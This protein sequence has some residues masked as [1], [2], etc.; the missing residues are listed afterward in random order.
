MCGIAGICSWEG[1]LNPDLA[2]SMTAQLVHR[3]PDAEGLHT[4]DR[5]ALGV[6]RLAIMDPEHGHQPLYN[7]TREVV[8]V[9][10]GEIYNHEQLRTQLEA[11]GHRLSSRSDGAVLAHLYEELGSG[12]VKALNGIFAIA[13]WD[14]RAEILVLARDPFGVKPLYWTQA[15]TRVLFASELKAL[16]VDP[17]LS[18]SLDYD[19]IND[20][21]TYRFIPSPRTP[22]A[23]IHKV[24]PG[25]TV[26]FSSSGSEEECYWTGSMTAHR[27][28][29][30]DLINEYSD[31]FERAVT[32][33]MMSDRPI[34]V[35]L[36]GGLDSAAITAVMAHR[37][38]HV[39][40]F[41]VGFSEGGDSDE[42]DLAQQTAR[43]FSTQHESLIVPTTEYLDQL[44]DS[45]RAL[46]EPVGSSSALAVNYVARLMQSDVPVALCGQGAD[47][48]L[49]GYWRY[50]GVKIAESARA[51]R[52][53][54]GLL[55]RASTFHDG[56]RFSRGLYT[57]RADGSV[58]RLMAAYSLFT[59]HQKSL[60]Y[61]PHFLERVQGRRPAEAVERLQ[62]RVAS[63][64][65]LDQMLYVDARLWLPDELLL[66]A[67]KMSMAASVE[68]RVP[69][70]DRDLVSLIESMDSHLKVNRLT[71]KFLHKRA[72]LRWLPRSIVYRKERGWVTPMAQWLRSE[73]G[74]TIRESLFAE[75]GLCRHL[76]DEGQLRR[77]VAQHEAGRVDQ[78]RQLF[79]L[80]S[81]ALWDS[82]FFQ[83]L[84]S[85]P[86]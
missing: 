9:F 29:A 3:G 46:E 52:P 43:L 80:L 14:A 32:R 67:D 31:T 73:L 81:L 17:A 83:A 64:P 28:N 10:N 36:S 1:H 61:Q 86:I 15:A 2:A 33:Q 85:G 74:P 71:R 4:E 37:S 62:Q 56:G 39:R 84:G 70:L 82:A 47:E 63:L 5:V 8:V 72:M 23:G 22:F 58:E 55:Q 38:P 40:T 16:F 50:L 7:E 51:L 59:E 48:L 49:G 75:R 19:A 6:R 68:L 13:V 25:S 57:L 24:M 34:G 77:L 42:T 54:A 41:T 60:F 12:F 45:Y 44:P 65:L 26:S 30:G 66:I 53:L 35:M 76:F 69:F 78:S 21:L 11:K 20:F 79:C 18:R 27:T